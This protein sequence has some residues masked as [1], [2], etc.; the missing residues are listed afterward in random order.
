MLSLVYL[1]LPVSS[2]GSIKKI[3]T[4]FEE[5]SVCNRR[6]KCLK[7]ILPNKA[8]ICCNDDKSIV[9]FNE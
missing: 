7:K 9:F 4:I 2:L 1:S 6:F 3:F 5:N 8:N